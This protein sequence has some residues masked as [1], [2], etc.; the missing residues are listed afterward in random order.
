MVQPPSFGSWQPSD[1][2]GRPPYSQQDPPPGATTSLNSNHPVAPD[3][4]GDYQPPRNKVSNFPCL[5]C[6]RKKRKCDCKLPY[7][8]PCEIDFQEMAYREATSDYVARGVQ[9]RYPSPLNWDGSVAPDLPSNFPA[10]QSKRNQ[11]R[12]KERNQPR[13]EEACLTCRSRKLKCD[14]KRPYCEGCIVDFQRVARLR[15]DSEDAARGVQCVYDANDPEES[16]GSQPAWATSSKNGKEPQRQSARIAP[17][18]KTTVDQAHHNTAGSSNTL[19]SSVPPSSQHHYLSSASNDSA[20]QP[21]PIQEF[22]EPP[23]SPPPPSPPSQQRWSKQRLP[24]AGPSTSSA[25]SGSA[26]TETQG[27]AGG[28][29]DTLSNPPGFM[30]FLR[31]NVAGVYE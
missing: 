28:P 30:P 25:T 29:Y 22:A 1:S 13:T 19:P 9:C 14:G 15:P 24:P 2:G 21:D 18:E 20:N 16:T 27:D 26:A 3:L 12:T 5:T 8:S 10:P 6:Q 4:P 11:P 31:P 17:A 7:C 23:T